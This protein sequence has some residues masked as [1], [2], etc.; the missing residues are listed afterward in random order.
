MTRFALWHCLQLFWQ[1]ETFK[2]YFLKL[3][4]TVVSLHC[5]STKPPKYPDLEFLNHCI[6][7]FLAFDVL[8]K[9]W[10]HQIIVILL[11]TFVV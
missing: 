8:M 4:A 2:K 10:C 9:G 11:Y 6:L 3:T 7:V 1:S 5:S